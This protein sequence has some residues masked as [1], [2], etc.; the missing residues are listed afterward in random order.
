MFREY[1][2]NQEALSVDFTSARIRQIKE[3]M[4]HATTSA[5]VSDG[6]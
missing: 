3:I 6:R 2:K 1:T 5:A 4:H